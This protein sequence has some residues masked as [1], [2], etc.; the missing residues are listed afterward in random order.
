L[1]SKSDNAPLC[2]VELLGRVEHVVVG[3][4]LRF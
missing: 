1:K 2:G 3:G 4:V